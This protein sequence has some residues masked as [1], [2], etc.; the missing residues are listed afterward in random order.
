MSLTPDYNPGFNQLS[1]PLIE[2]MMLFTVFV[3]MSEV[4]SFNLDKVCNY[5]EGNYFVSFSSDEMVT[6]ER[7]EDLLY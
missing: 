3:N 7:I 1:K 5:K 2:F 4:L 6:K